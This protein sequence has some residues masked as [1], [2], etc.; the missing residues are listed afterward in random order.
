VTKRAPIERVADKVTAYFVPVITFV[1]IL[2]WIFWLA[3]GL[4]GVLSASFLDIEVGGWRT[5]LPVDSILFPSSNTNH[6][7]SVESY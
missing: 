6:S 1:A 3:L 4:G 2:T 7:S 5:S